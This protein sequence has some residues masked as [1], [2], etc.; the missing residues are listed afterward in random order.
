MICIFLVC[1][2]MEL[3]DFSQMDTSESKPQVSCMLL[4]LNL[5]HLCIRFI[6]LIFSVMLSNHLI[7]SKPVE[8]LFNQFLMCF[9]YTELVS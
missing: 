6:L 7:D 8:K 2:W 9:F 1:T 3:V 4:F 5:H